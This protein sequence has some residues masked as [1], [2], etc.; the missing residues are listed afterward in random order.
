MSRSWV[1]SLFSLQSSNELYDSKFV[2]LNRCSAASP[3]TGHRAVDPPYGLDVGEACRAKRLSV[4]VSNSAPVRP[5]PASPWR[6]RAGS[7]S[8]TSRCAIATTCPARS[9]ASP[10]PWRRW[11]RSASSG[12][13][14]PGSLPSSA[15]WC[16]CTRWR[17]VGCG[18]GSYQLRHQLVDLGFCDHGP[19]PQC[20]AWDPR[21]FCH[22]AARQPGVVFS[23]GFRKESTA[24]GQSIPLLAPTFH[25]E[26]LQGLSPG[27]CI[28]VRI[29]NDH[30]ARRATPLRSSCVLCLFG[31]R[32]GRPPHA[33]KSSAAFGGF[34]SF[35][36][37]SRRPGCELKATIV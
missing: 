35:V 30:L 28:F 5:F 8:R 11:R 19:T 24:L 13:R 36:L 29:V 27:S 3:L 1:L 6:Q 25:S 17:A 31:A 2:V 9:T 14:A 23:C 26:P 34:V 33:P 21:I 10:R 15:R 22:I 20:S 16:G 32:Y 18:A 7:S 12:A 4:A 37:P